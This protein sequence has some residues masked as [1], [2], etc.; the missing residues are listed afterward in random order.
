MYHSLVLPLLSEDELQQIFQDDHAAIRRYQIVSAVVHGHASAE[1][2]A[3]QTGSSAR[4]VRYLL[5]RFRQNPNI[6]VFRTQTPG[7]RGYRRGDQPV[8]QVVAEVVAAAPQVSNRLLLDQV[9]KRL[10]RMDA[11][12]SRATFYRMLASLRQEHESYAQNDQH[13]PLRT[14]LNAALPLL[15]EEPP[16]ALG[17]SLLAR[18]F[19]PPLPQSTSL[20]RGQILARIMMSQ[21]ASLHPGPEIALTDPRMR[22]YAILAGEFMSGEDVVD[23][24]ARLAI[25]PRTYYRAKRQALDRLV[26]LLPTALDELTPPSL[27]PSDPIP[28]A[29]SFFGREDEI[30]YYQWRLRRDNLAVIWGLAGIGKTAL[31]AKI[32]AEGQR[33]GQAVIWHTMGEDERSLVRDALS[34]LASGLLAVGG[35]GIA[36]AVRH[37]QQDSVRLQQAQQMVRLVDLLARRHCVVVLDNARRTDT[38]PAWDQMLAELRRQAQAGQLRLII[39]SRALP[40][41]AKGGGWPALEGLDERAAYRL[42][43]ASSLS[44]DQAT[45]K[46]IF[47]RTQG[48]PQLLRLVEAWSQAPSAHDPPLASLLDHSDIHAYLVAEMYGTLS[49]EAN[50]LLR[51][52]CVLRRPLDLNSPIGQAA[53][54][55]AGR[56]RLGLQAVEQ[57]VAR[58][59]LVQPVKHLYYPPPLV[60]EQLIRLYR[61]DVSAWRRLHKRI[62]KAYANIGD[63]AEAAYH[64]AQ[65]Q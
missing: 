65:S 2:A 3:A 50:K 30:S 1:E 8:S 35:T 63:Y 41:W 27:Q 47:E 43:E 40:D 62:A 55:E 15:S 39:L 53:I 23:L 22:L 11:Q 38:D 17:N 33:L 64:N 20:E 45:W 52:C 61:N 31:G 37:W 16:I 25:S 46:G 51:W 54:N 21:I 7:P 57:L 6:D 28:E 44:L 42:L 19:T 9:N 14:A 60:R 5:Q 18:L 32:A 4:T 36:E 26:A 48:H 13:F 59:L 10:E 58:A 49:V 29:L 56:R 34:A 12:L 24:Q